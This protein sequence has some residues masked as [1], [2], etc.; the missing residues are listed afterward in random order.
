MTKWLTTRVGSLSRVRP[1]L[2][3]FDILPLNND[4]TLNNHVHAHFRLH[5]RLPL[6]IATPLRNPLIYHKTRRSF[7]DPDP[8]CG[9]THKCRWRQS[10][11]AHTHTLT[12]IT[13]RPATL[14]H[15]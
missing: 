11:R 5:M 3:L 12:R 15:T 13:A 6:T 4:N 1:L 14:P 9:A 8:A 2:T 7:W 10:L